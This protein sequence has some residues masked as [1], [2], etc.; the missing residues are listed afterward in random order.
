[1]EWF[2]IIFTNKSL[3]KRA[4]PPPLKPKRIRRKEEKRESK[5]QRRA[6]KR[7][8]ALQAPPEQRLLEER[9]QRMVEMADWDSRRGRGVK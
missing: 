6:D 1:M 7:E 5:L 9:A 8:K 4:H 2:L 3:E